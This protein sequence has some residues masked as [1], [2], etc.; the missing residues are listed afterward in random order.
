MFATSSSDSWLTGGITELYSDS[1]KTYWESAARANRPRITDAA[2]TY[3]YDADMSS[4][5]TYTRT[6]FAFRNDADR[7][8]FWFS[9]GQDGKYQ[10]H[11]DN[12]YSF[13]GN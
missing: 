12:L 2:G 5:K 11:D 8:S 4:R 9:A 10:T 7:N 1:T 3:G 6:G 13:E